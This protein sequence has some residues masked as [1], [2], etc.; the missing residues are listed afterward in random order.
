VVLLAGGFFFYRSRVAGQAAAA[1]SVQ[2]ATVQRGTVTASLSSAGTVR[3]AQSATI[4]WQTSGKVA[5]VNVGVG[6]TVQVNQELA[7]LDTN[8]LSPEVMN[9]QQ[10][11]V[12]AQ[13][14]LDDLLNS[15][16][17][18]AQ[19]RQDLVDAQT[20]LN[21]VKQT[22]TNDAAQAQLTLATAQKA[23]DDAVKKRNAMNY[24]H[25]SDKLVIEN[26]QVDYLLAKNDYKD[27]LHDFEDVAHKRLTNPDRVAALK[28]LLTAKQ[29]MDQMLATYNWYILPWTPNDIAQA[30][31]NVSVT[32]ANLDKAQAD[33]EILK[34]GPNSA[35]VT[36]AEAKLADAQRA[37]DRVK[38]GPTQA[39]ITAAQAT[40]DAAKATLDSVYLTAPFAGTVTQL[41]IKPGDIVSSG[42]DAFRIDDMSSVYIDLQVSEIDVNNL[43]LNQPATLTF[44]AIPDNQYTGVVTQIG[45]VG[46]VSQGVVNYPVTVRIDNPD[47][48]VRPGMTAALSVVIN[49]HENVLMVPN[50]A[51][52][53]SGNQR[54]VTVLFEGQQI[55]VPVT[56]GLSS[57]TETEVTGNQLREGDEVVI[58]QS[59]S[60]GTNN[61]FRPGGGGGFVGG[62]FR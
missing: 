5:R 22:A 62:L 8:T 57:D 48:S 4:V 50:Q 27:A 19:A 36:L 44:D 11:L 60:T 14:A 23:Y 46:T 21:A 7:A 9:A 45:I 29:K 13:K 41:D 40:V 51:I 20:A 3:S 52:R 38:D 34:D 42:T 10:D 43:K 47:P 17:Q 32:K 49:Q 61:G 56:V 26:A 1:V 24:P 59:A 39:D 54:T 18:Q 28:A 37:W 53:V 30:D 31:G 35:S 58:N 55:P 2:T 6:D 33:W 12:N 16:V 25:S 15:T